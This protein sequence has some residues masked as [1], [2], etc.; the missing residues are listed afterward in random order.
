MRDLYALES[1]MMLSKV[2]PESSAYSKILDK[3]KSSL[4]GVETLDF[5]DKEYL[6]YAH[7]LGDSEEVDEV[8]QG[9]ASGEKNFICLT[10]ISYRNQVYYFEKCRKLLR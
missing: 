8:V 2:L 7:V 10:P 6:L 5:S 4:Y 3:E 1:E 9:V